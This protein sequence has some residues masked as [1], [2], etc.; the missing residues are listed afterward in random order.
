MSFAPISIF[1]LWRVGSHVSAAQK[2]WFC[3]MTLSDEQTTIREAP[4][5]TPAR[6]SRAAI[7]TGA[8]IV[9]VLPLSVSRICQCR[10]EVRSSGI[11]TPIWPLPPAAEQHHSSRLGRYT[12]PP[13]SQ[14]PEWYAVP[15]L[16]SASTACCN[17]EFFFQLDKLVVK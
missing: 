2:G 7:V 8:T 3:S 14:T 16:T 13:G 4:D 6:L 1:R 10:G 5:A 12:V 17:A 9:T 15:G 11:A